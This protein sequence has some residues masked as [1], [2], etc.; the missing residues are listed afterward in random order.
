MKE[1]Y[2]ENFCVERITYTKGYIY[3]EII[4]SLIPLIF[5]LYKRFEYNVIGLATYS[6]DK[7]SSFSDNGPMPDHWF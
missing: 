6:C 3:Y 2:R 1:K 4:H 5:Y 7:I